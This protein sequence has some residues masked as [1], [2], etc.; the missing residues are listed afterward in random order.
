VCYLVEKPNHEYE[1]GIY[2]QIFAVLPEPDLSVDILSYAFHFDL[3]D[4]GELVELLK[5]SCTLHNCFQFHDIGPFAI[6][7]TL[8]RVA[9]VVPVASYGKKICALYINE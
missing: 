1:E 6:D 3:S 7:Y 2:I 5:L 9:V 8:S 4:A